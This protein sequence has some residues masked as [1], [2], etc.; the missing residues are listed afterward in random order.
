[1]GEGGALVTSPTHPAV[2]PPSWTQHPL[3][4]K[5]RRVVL[6]SFLLLLLGL[7]EC[8]CGSPA[9]PREGAV[10]PSCRVWV[11]LGPRSLPTSS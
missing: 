7:G 5:N 4:Q 10:L 2:L 8:P 1:M 3:I 9:Y 6:A 11:P